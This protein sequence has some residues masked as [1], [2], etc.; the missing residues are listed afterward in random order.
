M[1]ARSRGERSVDC[2]GGPPRAAFSVATVLR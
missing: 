2:G 1:A